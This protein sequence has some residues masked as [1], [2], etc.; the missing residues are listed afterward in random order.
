MKESKA[1]VMVENIRL[2]VPTLPL[3]LAT[4]LFYHYDEVFRLFRVI[5]SS[6]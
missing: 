4:L 3:A 2:E 6:R 5:A 1:S